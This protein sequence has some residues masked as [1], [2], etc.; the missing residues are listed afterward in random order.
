M[1]MIEKVIYGIAAIVILAGAGF[2][3]HYIW[4]DCLQENSVLTCMR[5]LH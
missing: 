3:Y 1:T 2:Y 4:S 5:M